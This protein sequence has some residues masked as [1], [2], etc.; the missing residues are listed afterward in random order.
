[1]GRRRLPVEE[2]CS[3][4]RASSGL[5]TVDSDP[6]QPLISLVST[7]NPYGLIGVRATW[8]K[9][10]GCT[11]VLPPLTLLSFLAF[12]KSR[13]MYCQIGSSA[14]RS[15]ISF[16]RRMKHLNFLSS[17]LSIFLKRLRAPPGRKNYTDRIGSVYTVPVPVLK[18]NNLALSLVNQNRYRYLVYFL[19]FCLTLFCGFSLSS[20]S[21]L[22]S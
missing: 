18:K 14:P 19:L 8:E 9:N 6:P 22:I 21:Y 4:W 3:A 17:F 13:N 2:I 11:L 15:C 7:G 1:M 10:N 20:F 5:R 16:V 12:A